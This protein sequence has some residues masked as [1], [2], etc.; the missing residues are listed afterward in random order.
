MLMSHDHANAKRDLISV[1]WMILL[2]SGFR[3]LEG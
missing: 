2:L 3:L 1:E